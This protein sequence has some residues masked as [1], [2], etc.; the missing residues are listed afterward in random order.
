MQTFREA[1]ERGLFANPHLK[2]GA[3]LRIGN[4]RSGRLTAAVFFALVS[5]RAFG[6]P[7]PAGRTLPNEV[8]LE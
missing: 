3:L 1:F 7:A 8:G 5:M 4:F 6:T 2:L